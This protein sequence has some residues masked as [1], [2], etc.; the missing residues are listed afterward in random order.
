MSIDRKD[1]SL[2]TQLAARLWAHPRWLVAVLGV[3]VVVSTASLP[4]LQV[5]AGVDVFFER[6]TDY[7]RV[8][9]E[10]RQRFVNDEVAY[11]AYAVN[12]PFAPET[13]AVIRNLSES[14]PQI[15]GLT[16]AG[17]TYYP[18]DSVT[19]LTTVETAVGG[20][21]AFT[22]VPL[23]PDP[24]PTD[25]AGLALIRER[26]LA[27]PIL[28]EQMLA[29]DGHAAMMSV[30]F[31]SELTDPQRAMAVRE[32]RAQL[33]AAAATH[34]DIRFYMV[35]DPVVGADAAAYQ[36][37]DLGR[38]IP[39]VYVAI[40]ALLWMFLRS[41]RGVVVVLI[42]ATI[43]LSVAMAILTAIGS[44]VNNASVLLPPVILALSVATILHFVVEYG[45]NSMERPHLHAPTITLAEILPPMW[46][47]SLT[48]AVGFASLATSRIPA[49]HDF[50]IA[51]GG[52]M[53]GVFV[54]A[55]LVAALLSRRYRA[56]QVVSG[57]GVALSPP[58]DGMLHRLANA[59]IRWP[60]LIFAGSLV[61]VAVMAAGIPR[62]EVD[63][64][65]IEF[66]KRG[67]PLREASEFINE[68]LRGGS[69]TYVVSIRTQEPKRF[70]RPDELHK[71][72]G[73]DAF[74]RTH[75][76]AQVV[77]S[78]ADYLK[79]MNR[80][81]NEGDA[82]EYRLPATEEQVA[83][84]MLL[85]GDTTVDEY[86]DPSHRWVRIVARSAEHHSAEVYQAY[87]RI[88][89]YLS[90]HFPAS[91][92]YVTHATGASRLWANLFWDLI[93]S[94]LMSLSVS[95]LIIFA[96]MFMMFRSVVTGV[97][98]IPPN[99]FPLVVTFGTMGWVGIRLDTAT[100]MIATVALGIAVDDTIHLLQHLRERLS[101]GLDLVTALRETLHHKGAAVI[102]TSVVIS[103]GFAV[104]MFASFV[105]TRNFGILTAVAMGSALF[106]DIV[107]LPAML[108]TAKTRLGATVPRDEMPVANVSVA[109][110]D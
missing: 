55:V 108:L 41:V 29:A 86:I 90:E 82:R 62:I 58:F 94:Q 64:S 60:R 28:G 54:V 6:G 72:E 67:T 32:I 56:P 26:A 9:E 50:G 71:L 37:R 77:T 35:G 19:S 92:G 12:D 46:M 11:V 110:A 63:Q 38:F 87:G 89:A 76:A 30:R 14:L 74:L 24:L 85:N 15:T 16:D 78:I 105:P 13:L 39:I 109:P 79:L 53:I 20:D 73:L 31:A 66:F 36:T 93:N 21:G 96:V 33:D 81:F 44:N 40:V 34:S 103:L 97:A 45:R 49:V 43:A 61:I 99:A 8:L 47:T 65:A 17:E 23:A 98:S 84:L 27:N 2:A 91:Q 10:V 80:E 106:G 52:A 70:L 22:S 107:M 57:R 18:I 3:I 102:A 75:A 59:L 104:L 48:T 7:R 83:Q 42:N 100:V 5:E 25:A 101:S 68:H 88:E 69:T 51:A 4:F 1:Q 95:G